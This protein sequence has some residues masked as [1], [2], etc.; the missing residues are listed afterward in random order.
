MNIL[1]MTNNYLPLFGGLERSIE[2]F[3]REFERMGHRVLIVAPEFENTP[4]REGNV[5][6]VPAI[7]HFNGSDFS[8]P[9]LIPGAVKDELKRFAPDVVHA[10][11]P[12]LL[13]DAAVRFAYQENLPLVYTQ[14]TLHEEYTHYVSE[15]AEALKRFIVEL[16]TGFANL[17]DAVIAPTRSIA[18]LLRDRGVRRPVRVV[19]TGID[20]AQYAN[21]DR[22]RM[23]RRHGIPADAFTVGHVGR[24]A[25]EKNLPFLL[26]AVE[27]FLKRKRGA[28]FLLIGSG[29]CEDEV[30][31]SLGNSDLS[32]RV[33][34]A[35]ALHGDDLLDG[36]AAMDAFAFSSHSETQGVVLVEALAAGVPLVG[37]DAIAVRDIIKDGKNGFLIAEEREPDFADAL[38]RLSALPRNQFERFRK[39]AFASARSYANNLV[40]RKAVALY[41]S[42]AGRKWTEREKNHSLWDAA[43]RRISAEWEIFKNLGKATTAAIAIAVTE[44]SDK[45]A[46]HEA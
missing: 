29:P 43:L 32:R 19:P 31:R 18:L 14:H 28:H 33:H 3:T 39:A 46:V 30:K 10:H 13:G 12:F 26:R 5:I 24:L 11:H 35:G 15:K 41:E 45:E 23:R 38:E 22:L 42:L 17:C 40:A 44:K 16:S 9:L 37:L 2:N 7:Q 8:A 27:N 20:P 6:R 36:F 1:M 34:F 21:R 4:P 25:V